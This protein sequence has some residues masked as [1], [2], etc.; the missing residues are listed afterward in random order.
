MRETLA[1]ILHEIWAHWMRY[2]FSCC[3][4]DSATGELVIPSEHWRR[5]KRQM[6]TPYFELSEE[7]HRSDREQADKVIEAL[8][9]YLEKPGPEAKAQKEKSN[10]T[11]SQDKQGNPELV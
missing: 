4:I 10:Y 9:R 1:A 2:L 7:E 11:E 3:R 6:K 8:K 5:W